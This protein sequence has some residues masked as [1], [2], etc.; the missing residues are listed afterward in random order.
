MLKKI[1]LAVVA[2]LVILVGVIAMQ[3]SEFSLQRSATIAAPP[4]TVFPLVNDFHNWEKWSPW[5]KLDPAMKTT[6]DGPAS[7][8]DA[9]YAWVGN[10]QVGEGKMTILESTPD[11]RIELRL[12]FIKPFA[13][14]NGTEFLFEPDGAGTKVT[15]TMTGKN[16][17]VSKAFGLL[18][19]MDKMVGGD[20]EK[21]LAQM[22][23]AAESAESTSPAPSETPVA[24]PTEQAPAQ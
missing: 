21:G 15:W 22:K 20:F 9:S 11:K 6:Y 12:E 23:V 18:M 14:V 2:V 24:A 19:D 1:A 7:G 16:G 5:A 10:S 4:A 17:F 8:K 13:A 3:P